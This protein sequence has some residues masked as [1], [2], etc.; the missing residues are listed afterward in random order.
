MPLDSQF[1]VSAPEDM[2]LNMT[3][4]R[5]HDASRQSWI[6]SANH[7][8]CDFPLPMDAVQM[9]R[10]ASI[11][12]YTDFYA[13]RFHA[14]NVGSML[15]PDQPLLL[16]YK[17]VPVGY[18]GRSSSIF[19]SGSPVHRPHGQLKSP[20]SPSPRFGP[21]QQLD[22]ELELG[23]F[24]GPGNPRV[25]LAEAAAHLFGVVL[26]NDW[27]ARDI[28]SWEYQPLGPFLAK[29]FATSISPWVV[30]MEA[31]AP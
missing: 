24:V 30:T 26:L 23:A 25:P 27:S 7:P 18:H 15:R 13:S 3:L 31:L 4:N 8:L 6:E 19:V 16:N 17:W 9:L 11:G 5:T 20:E 14:T 10:P 12:D 1:H 28:Q 21:S 2:T 22:Y 29:N